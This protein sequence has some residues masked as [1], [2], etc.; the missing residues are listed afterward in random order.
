MQVKF[1]TIK[2]T[3]DSKLFLL[4]W[5]FYFR[6]GSLKLHVIVRDD[7]DTPH[8]HPWNYRSF[9]IIPYKEVLT[10]YDVEDGTPAKWN[11]KHLPL[12]LV[13]RDCKASHVTSLYSFLGWKI[14]A[15]TIGWYSLKEQL[16]S[17]CQEAG[18]CKMNTQGY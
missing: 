17:F 9:L 2:R 5:S 6:K 13:T 4:R 11:Y 7:L 10:T 15:I 8:T 16:C 12:T 14:P 3:C 18:Y 1:K